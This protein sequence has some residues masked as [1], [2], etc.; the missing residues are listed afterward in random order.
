MRSEHL[1]SVFKSASE[2]DTNGL[3]NL[4]NRQLSSNASKNGLPQ[5][6]VVNHASLHGWFGWIVDVNE[7]NRTLSPCQHGGICTNTGGGFR[8]GC[9]GTGYNGSNCQQGA[10]VVLLYICDHIFQ[11]QSQTE[12]VSQRS[13]F[14]ISWI[15]DFIQVQTSE[16]W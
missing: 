16:A 9:S 5:L 1:R 8:C 7:C 4:F 10:L 13:R 2:S 6:L 15:N 3:V 11:V 12:D 14:C